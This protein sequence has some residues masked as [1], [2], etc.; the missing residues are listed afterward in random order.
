MTDLK[1]ARLD[2]LHA[3][4]ETFPLDR[5]IR[6]VAAARLLKDITPLRT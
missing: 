2:L 6:A 3:G 5:N 1:L 4:D